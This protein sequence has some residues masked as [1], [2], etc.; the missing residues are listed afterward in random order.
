M[1][2]YE[3]LEIDKNSDEP[4][5]IQVYE[6]IKTLIE[7][8]AFKAD[9]K[10]PPIRELSNK[11]NVNNVTVVNAYRLLEQKGYVYSKVG[12]GT[13][14]RGNSDFKDYEPYH[15][16]DSS[17]NKK[18]S[19]DYID[20]FSMN[21]DPELFPVDDFKSVLNEV[22]DRDKGYAFEHQH[23]QG[24][25]PLRESI[26]DYLR[27]SRIPCSF[28]NIHVISGAQ[29]GIDIISKSLLSFNDS[30]VVESPTYGGAVAAFKSRGASIIEVPVDNDGINVKEL[31]E[32]LK[33]CNPKL[34]YIMTNYQ[35]PTGISYSQSKKFQILYL[36]QKYNTYI[37]E[38]DYVSELK[39]YGEKSTP[40]KAMDAKDRVIYLK[41]FSKILMPGI[42][43]AFLITPSA[44]TKKVSSVKY[45]TD[46][47]TSSLMQRAFDLYLRKGM[48]N[49]HIKRMWIIYKERYDL[50]IRELKNK[51][52]FIEFNEPYGGIHI[53]A[54]TDVSSLI[55]SSA[56]KQKGVL[57]S[58][59]KIF[60]IDGRDTQYF[61]I[62]FA[63]TD[64][65]H[66]KKGIE[67]LKEAYEE[68]RNT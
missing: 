15:E 66:I 29:Q 18:E 16:I 44:I 51:T 32:V 27:Q 21:P 28:E 30:I 34:I 53:W 38:D 49:E 12:S 8:G 57:I 26:M 42:R 52:S 14:V 2:I 59:G 4:L 20:L 5:Y 37:L 43:L 48:W 65:L 23:I 10:L 60:Y 45:N 39:Y 35:N 54:R 25:Y 3:S 7:N 58:P 6:G 68:V 33:S 67:I 41:S 40:I 22:L 11:L 55:L 1:K 46:I 36:A 56:A 62:S 13:F 24:Y 9:E 50:L 61:R 19:K 63:G 64:T 47:S 17:A 31:E